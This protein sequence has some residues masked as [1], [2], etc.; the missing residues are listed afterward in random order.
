MSAL[1]K[2]IGMG[3]KVSVA[4]GDGIVVAVSH[5]QP[6]KFD[7]RLLETGTILTLRS[8]PDVKLID[9]YPVDDVAI[10]TEYR[11]WL[12]SRTA[13]KNKKLDSKTRNGA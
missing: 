7:I 2:A 13:P 5:T 4:E 12:K 6:L 8:E 9:S 10:P 11:D 1:G 3:A